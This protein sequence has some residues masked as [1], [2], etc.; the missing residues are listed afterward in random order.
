MEDLEM[1]R[2]LNFR[3][4]FKEECSE[5]DEASMGILIVK[6]KQKINDVEQEELRRVKYS[7][8]KRGNIQSNLNYGLNLQENEEALLEK[9][10]VNNSSYIT[11]RL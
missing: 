1:Q 5:K 8:S 4:T 7:L 6:D 3:D 10:N 2:Y 11:N 9:E